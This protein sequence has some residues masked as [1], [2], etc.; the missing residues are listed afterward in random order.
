MWDGIK[1]CTL[2]HIFIQYDTSLFS[3][4]GAITAV[5]LLT[6]IREIRA[7]GIYLLTSF[8]ITPSRENS[9][10]VWHTDVVV[11]TVASQQN[12]LSFSSCVGRNILCGV[13][14]GFH[15]VL[16][17]LPQPK[18]RTKLISSQSSSW[19]TLEESE[20]KHRSTSQQWHTSSVAHRTNQKCHSIGNLLLH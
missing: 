20:V 11:S 18:T 8:L 17:L 15:Q 14:M 6:N 12:R 2:I 19:L 1:I 7:T 9:V 16:W 3:M 4:T 13:C 10:R 5:Y